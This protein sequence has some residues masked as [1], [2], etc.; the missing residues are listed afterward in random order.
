ML[1]VFDFECSE[2]LGFIIKLS[3]AHPSKQQLQDI[4]LEQNNNK[5]LK[6]DNSTQQ[7]AHN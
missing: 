1:Q 3:P 4:L 5:N 7:R 2:S 6:F